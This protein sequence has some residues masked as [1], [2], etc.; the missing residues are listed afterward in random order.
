MNMIFLMIVS[1]G[2]W[3]R[4]VLLE[5]QD[6]QCESMREFHSPDKESVLLLV[7]WFRK[8][9]VSRHIGEAVLTARTS[10]HAI[11]PEAS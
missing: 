11:F 6:L 4:F 3:S 5:E 1:L 2:L 10:S 7:I 8:G 9:C